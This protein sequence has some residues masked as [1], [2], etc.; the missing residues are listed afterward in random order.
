MTVHISGMGLLRA[1]FGGEKFSAVGDEAFLL[2]GGHGEDCAGSG[3]E[4]VEGEDVG[5][6][7]FPLPFGGAEDVPAFDGDPVDAGHVGGGDNPFDFEEFGVTLWT[8]GV[9]D[10]RPWFVSLVAVVTVQVDK[11]EHL[12]ADGLVADPEDEV[13]SPLHGLDGM[14]EGQDIGSNAFGVHAGRFPGTPSGAFWG[15]SF[16]IMGVAA[17]CSAKILHSNEFPAKYYK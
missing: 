7:E 2:G 11:G 14:R 1:L 8:G 6:L 3:R 15:N 12:A 17:E 10:D 5:G 13:G 9:G 16:I 4:F